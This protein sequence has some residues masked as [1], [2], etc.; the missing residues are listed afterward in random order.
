M[1]WVA[2]PN[3][4]L[5][6]PGYELGPNQVTRD[7]WKKKKKSVL[8][9]HLEDG[10]IRCLLALSGRRGVVVLFPSRPAQGRDPP[11]LRSEARDRRECVYAPACGVRRRGQRETLHLARRSGSASP[12]SP[13]WLFSAR[14]SSS[15][16]SQEAE[17]PRN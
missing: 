8:K 6:R 7:F 9:A 5:R 15:H 4:R 12:P 14:K 16:P 10:S 2:P 3:S 11:G 1:G 17:A 13:A